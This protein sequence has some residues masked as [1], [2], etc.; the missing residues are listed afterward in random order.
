M[1]TKNCVV[2]HVKQRTFN[3]GKEFLKNNFT[4]IGGK[5]NKLHYLWLPRRAYIYFE[6]YEDAHRILSDKKNIKINKSKGQ[7]V[8]TFNCQPYKTHTPPAPNEL[9]LPCK[10]YENKNFTKKVNLADRVVV[11]IKNR[12][13]DKSEDFLIEIFSSKQLTCGGPILHL[14]LIITKKICLIDYEEKQVANNMFKKK[15]K[16]EIE[17]KIYKFNCSPYKFPDDKRKSLIEKIEFNKNISE[18]VFEKCYL[19]HFLLIESRQASLYWIKAY[20][21]LK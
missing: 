2:V 19:K 4:R 14:E 1:D 17:G 13:F 11:H 16:L 12:N 5:I 21:D 3:E 6:K 18:N 15:L 8:W 9:E 20:S 10:P 7:G